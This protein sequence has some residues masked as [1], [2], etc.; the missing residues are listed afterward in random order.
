M[1]PSQIED[2]WLESDNFKRGNLEFIE[3]SIEG[4]KMR[5]NSPPTISF[6]LIF[7]V[8]NVG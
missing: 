5:Q 6:Q 1:V 8:M 3:E 4:I 2:L 7:W